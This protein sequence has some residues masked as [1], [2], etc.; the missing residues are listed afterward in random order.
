MDW[1]SYFITLYYLLPKMVLKPGLLLRSGLHPKI[2]P[3]LHSILHTHKI[4]IIL[5]LL[6]LFLVV[7]TLSLRRRA[8]RYQFYCL[9]FSMLSAIGVVY[10]TNCIAYL[11]LLGKVWAIFVPLIVACN[12]T[13][14][15]LVGMS[16]GRTSL[17][18]LSPNKTVEGFLGGAIMTLVGT[19]L[20]VDTVM[21]NASSL[22]CHSNHL[23]IYPFEMVECEPST[24]F[25]DK[26]DLQL[27]FALMG[28]E[29]IRA[30]EA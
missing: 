25:T 5:V 22:V 14:A 2:F 30:S 10:A 16:M 4:H 8:V 29:T 28:V 26:V 12:D 18:S 9:G 13:S 19:Y 3:L 1:F 23:T 7:F 24:V 6:C 20:C 27:P 11:I 17:I 21:R 15:Y